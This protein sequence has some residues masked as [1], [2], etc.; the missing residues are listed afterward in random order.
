MSAAFNW[1]LDAGVG[2]DDHL[3]VVG[4]QGDVGVWQGTDPSSANTFALKGVWYVGP[5]PEYGRYFT[6][7]GGDV[8]LLSELG[9][10]QMSK[11]VNGQFVDADPGPVQ[12]IQ[13]T[14]NPLVSL[15]R[16][17]ES[18]DVFVAP[19]EDV[20]VIRPPKQ[21]TGVY[22][23]FGMNINTAAWCTFSNMSMD[24][25]AVL[26]G[27]TYFA[28]ETGNVYKCFYGNR[29]NVAANG[30]GGDL[31]E[32]DIQTSFQSFGTPGTLKKF[33]LARPIFIAPSA[34]A[35]KLSVNVQ[36]SFTGV[37]GSPSFVTPDQ[38]LWDTGLWNT[39]VWSGTANTYQAFVGVAGM[40]YYGSLRM[41]IRALSGTVFSSSHM[42]FENGGMM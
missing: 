29:D 8:L 19:S 35:V 4:T 25:A 31:V 42:L 36:Y 15:L 34:P 18:W 32:G 38:S 28:T 23:Q 3:V 16:S 30:T 22:Q 33:G 27:V 13:S 17:T 11:L 5:V 41:K 10:I 12:K 1:T 39:A 14:L 37:P 2:I 40:G 9:L 20:L 26:A 24:C 21:P 7:M 6:P